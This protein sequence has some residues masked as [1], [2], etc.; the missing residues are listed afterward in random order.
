KTTGPDKR[1][2]SDAGVKIENDRWSLRAGSRGPTLLQDTHFYKK[3]SHFKRERIPEKVVHARGDGVYGEIEL[4][5]SL[6]QLTKAKF[7]LKQ[8]KKKYGFVH[9]SI[10]NCSKGAK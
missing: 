2:T 1:L 5:K 8:E 7:Y 4:Y 6:S 9:I 10:I 3:K